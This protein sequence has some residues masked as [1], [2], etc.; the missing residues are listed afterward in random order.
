MLDSTLLSRTLLL[1]TLCA[2]S[3]GCTETQSTTTGTDPVTDRNVTVTANKPLIPDPQTSTTTVEVNRE[4]GAVTVDRT[5][6][7]VNV[8]DQNDSAITPLN[9]NENQADIKIT[10]DIRSKVVDTEM[11]VGAQNVKIITQDG[12]VTL[13]GPVQTADEKTQIE[14]I[15][16]DV[17]GKDNVDSQ[18][19]IATN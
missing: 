7:G 2:C 11:S 12:K 9:Q 17:A 4:T 14:D 8:R 1:G 5:N 18:L 3:F 16:R 10:A 15:A 13:Q 19:E 6:T